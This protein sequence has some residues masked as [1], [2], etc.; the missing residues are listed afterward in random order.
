MGYMTSREVAIK[1]GI[2]FSGKLC[3]ANV[4]RWSAANLQIPN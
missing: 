3:R 1:Y 4:E 2:A